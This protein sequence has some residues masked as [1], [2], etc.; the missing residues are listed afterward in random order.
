MR[1]IFAALLICFFAGCA[2]N[3][4]V[5][6]PFAYA[7]ED[8]CW[9]YTPDCEAGAL[10]CWSEC[11]TCV[12][13]PP[14]KHPLS[15][16]EALDIAL[17]NNPKT[18][19]SWGHAR[20]AA[21]EYGKS[22][23]AFFPTIS[24]DFY[25]QRDRT[26]YLASQVEQPQNVM[27]EQ[28]IVN[29]QTQWAPQMHMT[30]TLL[31]FGQRRYT[32]EAARYALYYADFTHNDTIQYLIQAV[33]LTYYRYLYEV[34]LQEANEADL[35]NAQ[36]TLSAADLGLSQGVKNISDVLQARSGVLLA[37]ITLSEQKKAV[38]NAYA[39]I[40]DNMGLP[41]NSTVQFEKLPFVDLDK[42]E[43][44]SLDSFIQLA[45]ESRPDLLASR[46]SLE[47]AEMSLHAAKRLWTPVV[48]YSLEV[49]RTYFSGGFHD[50]YDFTSTLTV[51][52]PL[53]TG[54]NIRNSVRA[55]R[56]KVETVTGALREKE[57]A[58]IRDLKVAHFNVGA[59]L[60]TLGA[61]NRY[62][63]ASKEEYVVALAQY[64]AGVNTILDVISAQA[65]LFDSRAKQAEATEQWFNSLANLTYNAGILSCQT[66]DAKCCSCE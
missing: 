30:W 24:A 3:R 16:A 29:N 26:A 56:S 1:V 4:A 66:G 10:S 42:I 17:I 49:G 8:T 52:M 39:T 58:V 23:S 57:L 50:D 33:T 46:A 40:L 21:A 18:Q 15:L 11:A 62:L 19:I 55:A 37:E 27:M 63:K 28:L 53:F 22:Q 47:S 48:D 25:Y 20:E 6:D 54:Y 43:L 60:E 59:A 45:M 36:E 35:A 9:Y 7:P 34:K 32:S 38:N 61:A 44:P 31:D 41:A 12:E 13:S 51:S 14:E 64:K 2:V 5:Y 65:S